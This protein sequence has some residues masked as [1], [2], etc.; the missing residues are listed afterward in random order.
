[1]IKFRLGEN[2]LVFDAREIE[3]RCFSFACFQFFFFL[4]SIQQQKLLPGFFQNSH[5]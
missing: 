1:M 4:V 5:Y 2:T 3:K